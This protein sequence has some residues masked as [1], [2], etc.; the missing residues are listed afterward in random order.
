MSVIIA[1]TALVLVFGA[2]ALWLA[3]GG[4]G[5]NAGDIAEWLRSLGAWAPALHVLLFA[6][7]TVLFVPGSLFGLAGG[8][9]FGPALGTI[10]NLAGAMLGA[11][12]AFLIAR[13]AAAD[14]VRKKAGA[15]LER[16]I[17]GVEAEGWRFVALVRLVPLFPFSLSNYAFG[18]TRIPLAQYALASMISMIPGTLAYTWLGHAGR[19]AAKG[20]TDGI[21]YGLIGLAVLAA[22]AFAPRFISR[23]REVP[24][25]WIDAQGLSNALSEVRQVVV[26][27]VRGTDEFNGPLGHIMGALNIPVDELSRRIGELSALK[28]G[29]VV[30]VCKTDKR[31]ASAAAVL[32]EAGI[33]ADV[34]RGGM[35]AWNKAFLP[36][37]RDASEKNPDH[38]LR[39]SRR[40]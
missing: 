2:A 34:L 1:R 3:F 22:I 39:Q 25:R 11:V 24:Q 26:L 40:L 6:L 27:D 10:L 19:E 12:T 15:R 23:W 30:A 13:Y 14:L 8:A 36:V 9:L 29:R 37:E 32:R 16:L 17:A 7:G 28:G 21:Q 4:A 33:D 5:L 18:L 38:E 35:E 20:S 31:S